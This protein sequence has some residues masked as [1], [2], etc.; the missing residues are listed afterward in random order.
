MSNLQPV[1]ARN[2]ERML[3][4][5][6][7]VVNA[8]HSLFP[9]NT[10]KYTV[11]VN[12]IELKD[13]E[14]TVTDQK[15]ALLDGAS[16]FNTIY[17]DLVITDNATGKVIETIKKYKLAEIPFITNRSTA[18]IDG[19]DYALLNQLRLK[20]GIYT[21]QRENKVIE[22]FFNLAYG[23]N[24]RMI[25]EPDTG[26]FFLEMES[27]KIA[28]Y[29]ILRAFGVS[30]AEL[31]NVWG[32]ELVRRNAEKTSTKMESEI[33]KLYLKLFLPTPADK[34]MTQK[35]KVTKIST[36]L[37]KTKME[38]EVTLSTIGKQFDKVT[39]PA[40]IMTSK[41]ILNI[42][43]NEEKTDDRDNLKYQTIHTID[44]AIAENI[45]KTA[46]ELIRKIVYRL[47][48]LSSDRTPSDALPRN[49]FGPT[50][51]KFLVTTPIAS[52]LPQINP[53]D[54]MGSAFEVTHLGPGGIKD[55]RMVRNETRQVNASHVNIIDPI[56]TKENE[57]AGVSLYTTFNSF[58]DK[59]GNMYTSIMNVKTGK[60]EHLS[61]S[62]M[63]SKVIAFP[64]QDLT[65][66]NNIV[67]VLYQ[68]KVQRLPASRVEYQ[69]IYHTDMFSMPVNLVPFLGSITGNRALMAA[70]HMTHALPLKH[71]EVPL[72]Q[73]S[74]P[75]LYDST[76]KRV[77][78]MFLPRAKETGTV[79][80]ITED[81][82]HLSDK[83]GNKYTDQY[84]NNFPLNQKT[85]LHT[86]L[87]VKPG[88]KV[89][90]NQLL[91]DSIYTKDG[92]L[93]LG[94]NLRVAYLTHKG[95]NINDGI[96]VSESASKK[97]TSLHMS[98]FIYDIDENH[99]VSKLNF[100]AKFPN[101]F[102]IEQLKN[103]EAD[104]LIKNGSTLK[105]GDPLILGIEKTE[106]TPEESLLGKLHRTLYR[107]YREDAITWN[108]SFQGEVVEVHRNGSRIVVL[109]KSEQQAQVG[110]KLSQRSGGKGVITAIIP[111]ERMY[112]DAHGNTIELLLSPAGVISRQSP[113]QI[114]EAAIGKVAS[115]TGKPIIIDNFKNINHVQ[116]AKDLLKEHSLTDKETI[117]DPVHDRHIPGIMTGVHYV[118]KQ[119]TQADNQ[120]SARNFGS[121]DSNQIPTQGGEEGSKKLGLLEINSLISHNARNILKEA[122]VLKGNKNLEFWNAYMRGLPLPSS[123]TPF[124][125]DKL[126]GLMAASGIKINKNN[127]NMVASPLTDKDILHMSNGEI[128]TPFMVRAKDLRPE[129]NGL[130]DINTTGGL[131]GTNWSHI[132]L[133]EPVLNPIT[134]KC[135]Y[136]LLGVTE[137]QLDDM[138]KSEGVAAIQRELAKIDIDSKIKELNTRI[139]NLKYGELDKAIKQLKYLKA[140]KV[141]DLHPKD[142]YILNHI[143]VLPPIMRPITKLAG[144]NDLQY[145]STNRLYADIIHNNTTL[146]NVKQTF[147]TQ[148]IGNLRMTLQKTVDALVGTGPSPNIKLNKQGVKGILNTIA[149]DIPK[150]GYFQSKVV[151]KGQDLSARGVIIPDPTISMDEIKIPEE[152]LWKIYMP[153]IVKRLVKKGFPVLKAKD[154][155]DKKD[156]I[157]KNELLAE[158]KERPVIFNRAPSLHKMNIMGVYPIP[159]SSKT[160]GISPFSEEALGADFDGDAVQLHVPVS[161][162]AVQEA[163]NMTLSNMLFYDKTKKL[164]AAPKFETNY[165]IYKAINTKSKGASKAFNS[166]DDIK[167]AYKRGE[168]TLNTPVTLKDRK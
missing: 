33:N 93:A 62:D 20:S 29:P 121:Y 109:V 85:F 46:P 79:D 138:V 137:K 159:T 9:I 132:K 76:E 5:K 72:I 158:I 68:G 11:N 111:D 38:P 37:D 2:I 44:D 83:E 51:K 24:F 4:L 149:G 77:A 98:K 144:S 164:A 119:S 59:Q 136:V 106:L 28:L 156:I 101:E 42:L 140:L 115:K 73:T 122:S 23:K 78:S 15:K 71:R 25:L 162:K 8:L 90:K 150:E 95:L 65:N 117:Y 104:G 34:L 108:N 27:T 81:M 56:Y 1:A 18:I 48:S 60:E 69:V 22:A 87:L 142:A 64:K 66:K 88:D 6:E 114:L 26:I 97:L 105:E 152:M 155:V 135:V 148:D 166:Y 14:Y 52:A 110:D 50:V 165:G 30:D 153:M 118:L 145:S 141:S 47:D 35:E 40:I 130:Y 124:A 70:K 82:I 31:S 125:Y 89:K 128:T 99:E 84:E 39:I 86:E 12:N 157:A 96:V 147:G 67:D 3:W 107:P 80:K 92:T 131:T 63:E 161:P 146:K 160:I 75:F 113:S 120:F 123:K 116:Y 112:K 94:T 151:T 43:R 163:K 139:P 17:G 16:L 21:R 57:K 167:N 58:R 154:M 7:K 45:K 53:L 91:G 134:K 10:K 13:K 19:N 55:I 74:Y 32:T 102:N 129:A 100:T 126:L 61:T 54:I 133:E 41:K 103:I 36:Y 127:N 143:P 168:I 49:M